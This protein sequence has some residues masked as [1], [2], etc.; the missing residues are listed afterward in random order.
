MNASILL[1]AAV[2]DD[3]SAVAGALAGDMD[4]GVSVVVLTRAVVVSIVGVG[5]SITPPVTGA[6]VECD[7]NPKDIVESAQ[8]F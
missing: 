6:F 2:S 3:L 5:R 8:S 1:N 4:G 7:A